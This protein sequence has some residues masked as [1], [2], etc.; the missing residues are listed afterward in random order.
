MTDLLPTRPGPPRPAP[1]LAEAVAALVA[2]AAE[3]ARGP[4]EVAQ[5]R[6]AV[7]AAVERAEARTGGAAA[8]H[9]TR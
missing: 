1:S 6:A 2:L 8:P 4:D 3:R 9:G 5:L 7:L